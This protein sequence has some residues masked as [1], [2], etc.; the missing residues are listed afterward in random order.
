MAKQRLKRSESFLGIH[1]D[2]HA[3][4]DCTEVGKHVTPEMIADIISKVEPD[5]MQCDCKGHPGVASFPSKVST[6]VPGFEKDQLRIWRDVTA[7]RG[8]SLYMH[9]SGVWDNDA[10]RRF[11]AWAAVNADGT[12]DPQKS[13][14]FGPYVDELLIPQLK[15]LID[16]YG[17]DGVWI[18]GDCWA[19]KQDY[20]D[21]AIKKF[22]DQYGQV[23][24][25]RDEDDELFFEYS[26]MCRQA[27][28]VYLEHYVTELHGYSPNF[29][30]ASNWAYSSQMPEPVNIPVDYISGDYSLQDSVNSARFEGRCMQRQGKPWD[31]MAWAFSCRFGERSNCTKSIPQLKQEAAVVLALGGGFQAYFKQKRDGSIHPWE[32]KLMAAVAEFARERQQL[33]HR[34]DPVPQVALLYSGKAFYRANKQL[35]GGGWGNKNLIALRGVLQALLDSQHVVEI[36]MEHHLTGRMDEYECIVVPEWEYLEEDFADELRAYAKRG[37]SL[38][39]IGPKT[40][41]LF[42]NELGVEIHADTEGEAKRWLTH[43]GWNAG[44]IGSYRTVTAGSDVVE[45]GRHHEHNDPDFEPGEP[46]A[47]YRSYGKGTVGA[48]LFEFGKQYLHGTTSTFRSFLGDLVDTVAPDQMVSVSGSRYVDVSLT[49]KDDRLLVHLVNTAGPHGDPDVYVYDEVIPL[50]PLTVNVRLEKAPSAVVL[51]P[52][53]ADLEHS[54]SDGVLEVTVPRLEY[55]DIVAITE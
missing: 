29:Q 45:Y 9:Y 35:F 33:C 40:T 22:R 11:P 1:F 50:G 44:F 52:A 37:G 16:D 28:R 25:P 27:F 32:M 10:M 26:E 43:S 2:F 3:R 54:Y 49:R 20:C 36:C 38:L 8:V 55:Y 46:A 30:I 34:G 42:E 13:S 5:Y 6:P 14:L 31:L 21:A 24:I 48:V 51:E 19:T 12:A 53:G 23:D 18:D 15:E 39:L 17:V 4:E 41:S 7:E 47:I